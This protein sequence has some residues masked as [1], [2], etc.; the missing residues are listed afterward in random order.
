MKKLVVLLMV[1]V[2]A[3]SAMAQIDDGVNSFGIY[4]DE[5]ATVVGMA[6]GVAN[7]GVQIYLCLVNPSVDIV[8]GFGLDLH[9]EQ[10]GN[11]GYWIPFGPTSLTAP[12]EH[13][14]AG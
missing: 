7:Y 2:F 9:V 8:K 11:P 4:F 10:V 6:D 12:G 3:T 1:A 5:G 13:A 14:A